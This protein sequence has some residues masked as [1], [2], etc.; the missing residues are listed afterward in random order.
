MKAGVAAYTWT[1]LRLAEMKR[2]KAD[3]LFV[4]VAGEETGCQGSSH[5]ARG[6]IL[7]DAGAVVIAEPTS[8][9]PIVGHRG[10]LWLRAEAKGVTAHG[11]MPHLGINAIYKAANAIA[12]TGALQVQRY[13]ASAARC[14]D[15]QRW[16]DKRR[17]E[18]EFGARSC[19]VY[20][21]YSNNT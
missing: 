5:L 20:D 13:S 10:A 11:S 4:S 9:Y 3:L 17:H 21:G 8:N 18:C 19:G 2:G 7:G 1:A 16:N 6:Q 12:K 15:P 14:T